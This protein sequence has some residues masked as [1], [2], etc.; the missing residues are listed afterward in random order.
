M[1]DKI[2]IKFSLQLNGV[3]RVFKEGMGPGVVFT[4]QATFKNAPEKGEAGYNVFC[5]SLLEYEDEFI[6][7][8]I[9]ILME[10]VEND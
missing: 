9:N 6:K 4:Q 2:T 8:N 3:E 7:E 5:A 10:E 1:K